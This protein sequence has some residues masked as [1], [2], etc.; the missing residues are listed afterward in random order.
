MKR[1]G[2]LWPRLVSFTNLLTAAERAAAGKRR[3]SDVARFRLDLEWE[4]C[5]LRRELE[6]GSYQPGP[7]RTF[8]LRDPKPR[9]MSAAR[10]RD[11]VVH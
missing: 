2:N 7:Y 4:L 1:A 6:D 10:F 8:W 3:R 5:R 9:L 11:R